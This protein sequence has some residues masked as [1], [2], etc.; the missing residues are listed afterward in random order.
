MQIGMFNK[1]SKTFHPQSTL[2][3]AIDAKLL[4]NTDDRTI[5]ALKLKREYLDTKEGI[6]ERIVDSVNDFTEF[7][8]NKKRARNADARSKP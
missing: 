4:K 6:G 7:G 3:R 2:G 8:I 5:N 1:N